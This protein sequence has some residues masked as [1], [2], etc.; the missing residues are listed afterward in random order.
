MESEEPH[1]HKKVLLIALT[2]LGAVLLCGA[3]VVVAGIALH[4]PT[5]TETIEVAPATPAPTPPASESAPG[6]EAEAVEVAE[7]IDAADQ[8]WSKH[9]TGVRIITTLR[10]PVILVST[11]IDAE[12]ADLAGTLTSDLGAFASGLTSSGGGSY[13][14]HLRVLSSEG[15]VVGGAGSTDERWALDAPASPASADELH[16]WLKDVYGPGSPSPEGWFSRIGDIG[17]AAD[18]ADGYLVVRTDLN[19][20]ARSD[21][22][23]AQA[24][25]DAI[26]SSGA[27]FAPGIRV[28]FADGT[29]EWSSSLTGIDPYGP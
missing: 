29:F 25:I 6:I 5:P 28:L 21:L 9:I 13:T 20:G 17:G 16:R 18:S 22:E 26:N 27:T 24:I 2:V 4:A 8:E 11:D 10:R 3:G 23:T 7:A 19:Q 15:D 1:D 12:Q 14:F